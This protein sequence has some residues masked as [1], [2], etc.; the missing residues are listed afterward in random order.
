MVCVSQ[1]ASRQN[2]AVYLR[3]AMKVLREADG[4]SPLAYATWTACTPKLFEV[5]CNALVKVGVPPRLCV[6]KREQN[7]TERETTGIPWS[8]FPYLGRRFHSGDGLLV[9]PG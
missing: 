5:V 7:Q 3:Q 2:R 6:R 1:R 8:G 9:S 4:I